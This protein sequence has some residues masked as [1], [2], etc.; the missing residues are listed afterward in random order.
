MVLEVLRFV[1][2]PGARDTFTD[3]QTRL[4]G[5]MGDLVLHRERR[6]YA[7]VDNAGNA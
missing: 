1:L 6:V 7:G 3:L 2:R 4:D 5:Q